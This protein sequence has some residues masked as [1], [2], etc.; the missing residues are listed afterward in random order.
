MTIDDQIKMKSYN[1]ILI[2]KL[3]K[4]LPALL[5]GKISKYEY[6]TEYL[7]KNKQQNKLNF[8]ILLLVQFLKNKQKQ[9]NINEQNK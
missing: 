4:Y 7:I 8:L 9:L 2:E 5:S 1:L 3:Q 6:L